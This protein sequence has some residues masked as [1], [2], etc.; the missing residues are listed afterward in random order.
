MKLGAEAYC[1]HCS[2]AF[3]GDQDKVVL[4]LE[5]EAVLQYTTHTTVYNTTILDTFQASFIYNIL[6]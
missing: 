3:G 2:C 6:H 5:P 1:V 4:Y